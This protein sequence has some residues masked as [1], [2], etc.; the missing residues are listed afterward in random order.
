MEELHYYHYSISLRTG[1]NSNYC[2]SS[3]MKLTSMF[4]SII[5]SGSFSFCLTSFAEVYIV[6]EFL[7]PILKKNIKVTIKVHS[8]LRKTTCTQ[9]PQRD[10]VESSGKICGLVM[11]L[12]PNT[13]SNNNNNIKLNLF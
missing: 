4:I 13:I 11:D 3:L 5:N 1:I 12:C 7:F 6:L 10:A 8:W 9:G 2:L